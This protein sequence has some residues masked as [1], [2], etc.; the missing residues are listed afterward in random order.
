MLTSAPW[1]A[2]IFED[3]LLFSEVISAFAGP[4]GEDVR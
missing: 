2:E 4:Q 3:S 1:A